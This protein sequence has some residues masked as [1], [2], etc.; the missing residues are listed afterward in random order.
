M[1]SAPLRIPSGEV[2]GSIP[3]CTPHHMWVFGLSLI[4]GVFSLFSGFPPSAKPNTLNSD[5][6]SGIAVPSRPIKYENF[7][8]FTIFTS[9]RVIKA[10]SIFQMYTHTMGRGRVMF[11]FYSPAMSPQARSPHYS[12]MQSH[13]IIWLSL[14]KLPF[15]ELI[16]FI[17]T[18]DLLY[19]ICVWSGGS[20]GVCL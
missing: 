15:E 18:L 3:V 17:Y 11:T 14:D 8:S 16:T 10:S 6:I 13:Q 20:K 9:G 1:Y 19:W 12:P 4:C 5:W 7:E 2:L